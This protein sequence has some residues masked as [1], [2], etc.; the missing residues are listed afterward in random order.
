MEF[1]RMA[2]CAYNGLFGVCRVDGK[3]VVG[4]N[5]FIGDAAGRVRDLAAAGCVGERA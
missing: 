4:R 2:A 5:F 3:E 1:G